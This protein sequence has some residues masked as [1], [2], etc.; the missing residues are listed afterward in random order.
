LKGAEALTLP[1]VEAGV[2]QIR[3]R[4]D[5]AAAD[6][7]DRH[8]S[9]EK[10]GS[11]QVG[12]PG[13]VLILVTPCERA[14]WISKRH[15]VETMSARVTADGFP[16]AYR[17]SLFRNE[18]AGLASFLIREAV[19]LTEQI[20]GIAPEWV[21]YVDRAAVAS[22][23]PGYCFRMAGWKR[24][25]TYENPRLARFILRPAVIDRVMGKQLVAA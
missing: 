9:R 11:P 15:S 19:E 20:W 7:A 21:T 2:W 3:N 6:L 24:D 5:G 14:C 1:G 8:Y 23:N 10:V 18:G 17:C 13:F 22:R 16:D 25:R 4:F 12:G